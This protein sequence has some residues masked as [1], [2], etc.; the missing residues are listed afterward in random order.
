MKV[1]PAC[2]H[3]QPSDSGSLAVAELAYCPACQVVWLDFGGR[4][5]R[6]YDKLEAQIRHWEAN[7]EKRSC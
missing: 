6:F 2:R 3:K 7:L 5:P 4:R 1:C